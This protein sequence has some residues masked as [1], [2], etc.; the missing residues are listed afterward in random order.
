[1]Y[2]LIS[3]EVVGVL[4]TPNPKLNGNVAFIPIDVLQDEMGL[5]L[6]GRVTELL[7]RE[8]GARDSVIPGASESAPVITAALKSELAREGKPLPDD[9][10]IESWQVYAKDFIAAST[11]DD[12]STRIIVIVLF[13][14]SFLGIANTMLL[15]ILERT[16]EIGMMRAQG[17]TDGQLIFTYMAE[18]G[19]VGVFGSLLGII[20]GCLINVYMVNTG[21]NLSGMTEAMSGDIGYRVNGIFRSAWNVPVIIGTGIVATIISG[22]MAYFPT[23]KALK[24]AITESLRFD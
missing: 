10:A 13:V 8:K 19:M 9:L 1:V 21:I 20:L 3:A 16:K 14:L 11:G 15:A 6:E 4:N 2:Q 7:I 24:M 5:M 23:R 22:V 12:W 18:A 17:M